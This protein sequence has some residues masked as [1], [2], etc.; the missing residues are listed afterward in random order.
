VNDGDATIDLTRPM[1]QPSGARI[2]GETRLYVACPACGEKAGR[3]DH[4]Y[5][6]AAKQS[7]RGQSLDAGPWMCEECGAGYRVTVAY[8]DHRPALKPGNIA[9]HVR[10]ERAPEHDRVDTLT[11]LRFPD[12]DDAYLVVAGTRP[13]GEKPG[14]NEPYV[15]DEHTCPVNYLGP[16]V[17]LVMRGDDTDPHGLFAHVTTIDRPADI[18]LDDLSVA[19][20]R[21]LF[22]SEIDWESATGESYRDTLPDVDDEP[23]AD[24]PPLVFDVQPS[25]LYTL[26]RD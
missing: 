10:V 11:L 23:N 21:A 22:D 3:I 16:R 18:D 8:D 26:R 17:E 13:I 7:Y 9:P 15:Y 25:G 2:I 14:V 12:A 24:P 4:L 6:D 20:V 5:S 19:Q 1:I